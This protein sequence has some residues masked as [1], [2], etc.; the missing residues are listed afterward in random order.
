MQE[1]NSVVTQQLIVLKKAIENN[2][3]ET[4][5]EILDGL[6]AATME[7]NATTKKAIEML[8][9]CGPCGFM[10]QM[11]QA[12]LIVDMYMAQ[13]KLI[14]LLYKQLDAMHGAITELEDELEG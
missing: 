2:A 7:C 1:V 5:S 6:M 8:G 9:G 4:Q 10:F 3:V 13:T 12:P 11:S 14:I